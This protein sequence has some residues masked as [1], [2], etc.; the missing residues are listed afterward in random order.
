LSAYIV[1]KQGASKPVNQ[2]ERVVGVL[3]PLGQGLAPGL[4]ADVL[5]PIERVGGGA[6]HDDLDRPPGVVFL[7]PVR[8]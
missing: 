5:L 6:G 8:T 2:L 4:I 1:C 7:V 3:E